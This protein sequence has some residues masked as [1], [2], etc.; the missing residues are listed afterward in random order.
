[1]ER[2]VDLGHLGL[3]QQLHV[4]GNLAERAGEEPEKAGDLADAVAHG[5]PGDLGL[6]EAELLHQRG[7]HLEAVLAERG[8]RSDRAAEFADQHAAAA[9]QPLAVA[10]HGGEQRRGLE[11]EGERYRLL[12]VAAARHRR[13]AVAP[14]QLGERRRGRLHVLFDE[15]ERGADLHDRGGVGDVLRGRAPMAPLAETV[16]AQTDDL[17]H[18][19][20]DRIADIGLLL[21]AGEIDVLDPALPHDLARGLLGMMPRRAWAR[22]SAAS[23]SR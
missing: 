23:I 7:L 6:A 1:M 9:V 22:A 14:R 5:V 3:H 13:V 15:L 8:Q 17:L 4:H 16:A 10:L 12:Q 20:E 11:A 18:H 2:L 19:A 21:E